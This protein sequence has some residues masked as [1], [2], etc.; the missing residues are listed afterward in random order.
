MS[1]F[2]ILKQLEKNSNGVITT[3]A[4]IDSQGETVEFEDFQFDEATKF[5]EIMNANTT[6]NLLYF[7]E[8]V[9]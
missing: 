8:K 4:M 9:S 5:V 2:R 3:V 6:H 7:L 1:H